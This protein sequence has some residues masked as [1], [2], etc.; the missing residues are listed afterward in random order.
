MLDLYRTLTARGPYQPGWLFMLRSDRSVG[1]W[2]PELCFGGSL[3][4]AQRA[5]V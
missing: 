2:L 1:S 3:D 5:G 4:S